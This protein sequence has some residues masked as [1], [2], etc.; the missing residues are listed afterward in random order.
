MKGCITNIVFAAQVVLAFGFS[1]Y[2]WF[3]F[4]IRSKSVS[5]PNLIGKSADDAK[6]ICSHASA[7]SSTEST[8]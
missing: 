4:F 1:T 3:S 8:E 7:D 5:T 2:V 6:A